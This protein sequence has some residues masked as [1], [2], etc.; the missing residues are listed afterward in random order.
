MTPEK[1]INVPISQG[2]FVMPAQHSKQSLLLTESQWI[3]MREH[4]DGQLSIDTDVGLSSMEM[5]ERFTALFR[6]DE[7]E[8]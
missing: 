4:A 2:D 7:E 1:M 8:K 6:P 5:T 3:E